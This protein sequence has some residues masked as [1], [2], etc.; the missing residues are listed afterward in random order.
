MYAKRLYYDPAI[1][2]AKAF[3]NEFEMVSEHTD[4]LFFDIQVNNGGLGRKQEKPNVKAALKDLLIEKLKATLTEKLNPIT[5][6]PQKSRLRFAKDIIEP[7]G[8][9]SN[10]FG[11]VH[12]KV[13]R[14]DGWG[15]ELDA[16]PVV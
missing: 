15:I 11:R 1:L 10:G 12:G 16:A 5:G 6:A 4:Q 14:L 8:T 9:I 13:F 3:G 7:K 2:E